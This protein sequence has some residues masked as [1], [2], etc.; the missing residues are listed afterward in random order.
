MMHVTGKQFMQLSLPS[1][2]RRR[3]N[4]L[5]KVL[6]L[7][8]SFLFFLPAF[9]QDEVTVVYP[10][11]REPFSNVYRDLIAGIRSG[12]SGVV[13]EFPVNGHFSRS[14]LS[15]HVG[16]TE[17]KAVI[18]LG[19]KSLDV[20]AS[21]NMDAPVYAA[22]ARVEPDSV[23][24]RGILLE[25]DAQ[26]YLSRLLEIFPQTGTVHVVYNPEHHQSLID[27]A[28]V[29]LNNKRITFN[30]APATDVRTAALAFR[31]IVKKA[32]RNDAVWLMSD[33]A[34]IDGTL[35]KVV[36]DA[37]WDKRLA[38]FSSNPVFVKR[39]ALFAI[40]PDNIG[41]GHRLGRMV[42]EASPDRRHGG[43]ET[44]KDVKVAFNERTGNH[45]GVKLT[46]QTRANIELFLP[47]M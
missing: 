5:G 3:R 6:V 7:L 23:I 17:Q 27:T 36:L 8:F 12:Y 47:E 19:N 15:A 25:A 9:A 29:Y 42:D 33:A 40:Y 31:D 4:K 46:A 11:V 37:A 14:L 38:V 44:L 21:A 1:G 13:N 28:T 35:L 18:A 41:I 34:L 45:I 43:V 32:R 39:G 10:M 20:V 30:A 22:V 16:G 26:V 24:E 2:D